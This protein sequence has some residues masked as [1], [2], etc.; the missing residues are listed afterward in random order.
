MEQLLPNR[1][2]VNGKE[3]NYVEQGSGDA[4]IFVHGSIG[5][6]RSWMPQ[7]APFAQKYRAIAY[8]RR[9]HY[10]N[11]WTGEGTDYTVGLHA[12]D[13]IGLIETLDLG[14]VSGV[15]NSFGAYIILVAETLRPDLIRKLVIGEP[16]ILSWLKEIPGGL[17]YR[18]DFMHNTWEPASHAFQNGDLEKGVR[19]F[20]DGVSGAQGS[21]D[22]M[23]EPVKGRI[24]DNARELSA[25]TA[26]PGYF[27]TELTP[28]QVERISC[29]MLLL[30]GERSPK[31]FHLIMDR[32]AQCARNAQQATI[33]N[34]SHSMPSNNPPVY[35]QVVMDFLG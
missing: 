15:G 29:P 13:L 9:Y 16:P 30:R 4:V 28:Q 26:S 24:L 34:A 14:T 7:L 2:L 6:Y 35:N 10:P 17:P 31:M 11:A 33:P 21:F 25:E 19:L 8:S 3:L 20:L 12:D 22:Q 5:D 23:P 32:L 18:N 1:I 27:S